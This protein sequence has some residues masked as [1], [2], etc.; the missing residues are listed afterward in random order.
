[1]RAS[2]LVA[3]LLHLQTGG[4]ATAA[5]LAEVLEVSVRTIYRD[6][7]ALSEAG[8]P[9]YAEAGPGGGIRLV[10]GYRTRLTG[11]TS[12]E[13]DAVLL[14]GVP[15]PAAQLGLGTVLAAAQLKVMAALPPELRSRASRVQERFLLDA[16]GW[17]HRPDAVPHLPA[18]AEALWAD[19][20]VRVRYARRGADVDD[21]VARTLDP[22]GLVCK[23]GTWYLLARHRS[24]TRTYRVGRL[25]EV[26]VLDEAVVRPAGFVLAEEWATASAG[27]DEAQWRAEAE[28]LLT[29][30]GL[31]AL[32]FAVG[33]RAADRARATA[34]P[35]G[36]D[37]RVVVRVPVES[38]EVAAWQL[39]GLGER[40]EVI[41]PA[42]LRTSMAA[43]ARAMAARYVA[44]CA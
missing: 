27:F 36:P 11:L 40:C 23:A 13:A 16:P 42:E 21:C 43:T 30:D 14:A 17:F 15:G 9:V 7:A 3:L 25:V 41:A 35:P 33:P 6:V 1:M 22:L 32:G 5:R 18:V 31:D 37:G 44:P 28:V 10:D 34:G 2:R 39:L 12:E 29:P 26:Q 38:V 8:V 4:G 20:R 24:E 19:R